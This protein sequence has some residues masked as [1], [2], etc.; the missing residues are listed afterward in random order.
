MKKI[1]IISMGEDT[2]LSIKK[3][4]ESIFGKE[5]FI[6]CLNLLN[7]TDGNLDYDLIIFSSEESK[8]TFKF[9]TGKNK[10]YV[11]SRRV[12]KH[13]CIDE[14]LNIPRGTEVLLVNDTKDSCKEVIC[15]LKSQGVDHIEYYPYYPG[16]KS[17][18]DLDIAITPGE[19]HLVPKDINNVIDINCRHLD[20]SSLVEI[21]MQLNCMDKYGSIVSSYFYRD[22]INISKKY[23]NISQESIRLKDLLTNLLDNQKN[24]ILYTNIEDEVLVLNE[25]ALRLLNIDRKDIISKNIYELFDGLREDII[26]INNKEILVVNSMLM[27]IFRAQL[28]L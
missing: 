26:K 9:K 25:E 12:I 6:E 22:M 7:F 17:Y 14:I 23:I 5:F 15:Q 8:K 1:L 3:Q 10:K 2:G 4:L 13:E 16:V 18:K 24:G 28:R 11:V 21:L 19:S 20:V 27:Y